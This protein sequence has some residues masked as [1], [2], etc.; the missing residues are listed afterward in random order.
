MLY[1]KNIQYEHNVQLLLVLNFGGN[2]RHD[3]G[4]VFYF[5]GTQLLVYCMIV[6]LLSS[7]VTVSFCYLSLMVSWSFRF[8]FQLLYIVLIQL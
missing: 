7:W 8:M 5:A 1:D 2:V 6:I 4:I 3:V